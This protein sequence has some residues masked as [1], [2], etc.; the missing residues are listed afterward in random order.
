MKRLIVLGFALFVLLTEIIMGI[1]ENVGAVMYLVLMNV[2]LVII[3]RRGSLVAVDH[4]IVIFSIVPL[5]RIAGLFMDISY[6]WKMLLG[7]GVLLFLGMYYLYE[8]NVNI[9]KSGRCFWVLPVVVF[10]GAVAGVLA[11]VGFAGDGVLVLIMLLPLVVFS[12]E[13]FFR[14]L[15]QNLIKK[16]CGNFYSILVPAMAYGALSFYLGAWL[17]VL[18]FFVGIAS[19]LMYLYTRNIFVSVAFNLAVSVFVFVVP[20]FI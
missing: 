7:Y 10:C 13:I 12:E 3:S 4:M 17:A 18:F 9:G 6:I 1:S 20:G 2:V 14:G 5:V 8:F 19:G 15:M 16:C 11:N